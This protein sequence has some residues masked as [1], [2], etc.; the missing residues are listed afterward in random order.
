MTGD[1]ADEFAA[2]HHVA[3]LSTLKDA[4]AESELR[5]RFCRIEINE[6]S[7]DFVQGS[8]F[9]P[10]GEAQTERA[11]AKRLRLAKDNYAIFL[12][13]LS[14]RE[15]EGCCRG[16]LGILGVEEPTLTQASDDQGIDFYGKL[17]L[18]NRLDN[19]SELPGLDRRLN[20][21][22]VGQAKHYDKT[23]VSTPDIRELVGSVR[24]AQSGIAS[25]D[26]RA[27]SGFNP[28]LLDPVF[29]LFFTTGT[30]SRDGETLA[31]R[32]GMICMDGDQIATFL[33]DNEIGL[34]GDVFEQ[35]AALAWVRSHLH[36]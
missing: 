14:W 1:E 2:S 8:S 22:L 29:F 17:A 24:L 16:I 21:W 33:A 4:I 7:Q 31:A 18:G 12:R 3:I 19:F 11:R 34:T 36:Q 6:S 9:Y 30:I 35:D 15:F 5:Y 27:L 23:R 13:T 25:D 32:S 28:S 26:G 20:V 10:A